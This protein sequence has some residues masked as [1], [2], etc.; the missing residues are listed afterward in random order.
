[1]SDWRRCERPVAAN[2]DGVAVAGALHRL[3]QRV[4]LPHLSTL[5]AQ[6]HERTLLRLRFRL[7]LQ[8]P[9]VLEPL[10]IV[11]RLLPL[12]VGRAGAD[13]VHVGAEV[14]AVRAGAVAGAVRPE[15][16]VLGRER[17]RGLVKPSKEVAAL[18]TDRFLD[19]SGL[20]RVPELLPA[21]E[22]ARVAQ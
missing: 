10:L 22:I 4:E 8:L 19:G 11:R 14:F 5:A 15:A 2:L 20:R 12:L 21:G 1:D 17:L 16:E 9:G 18:E 13:Q 7:C 6:E 3:G